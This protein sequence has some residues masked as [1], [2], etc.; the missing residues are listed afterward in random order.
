MFI[1]LIMFLSSC[2]IDDCKPVKM[3]PPEVYLQEVKVD[4]CAA[5]T[6][7]DLVLCFLKTKKALKRAN[8][9]K[10]HIAEW[11]KK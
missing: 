7:D 4:T 1:C 5:V 6:N 9:D 11:A 3:A 10:R 8:E 2:A